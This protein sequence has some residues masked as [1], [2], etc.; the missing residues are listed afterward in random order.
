M[1]RLT[2]TRKL[3]HSV[4]VLIPVFLFVCAWSAFGAARKI[5]ADVSSNLMHP[6][7][8]GNPCRRRKAAS[9]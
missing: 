9:L 8:G 2:V 6:E 1:K 3:A 4:K 7:Q 5:I